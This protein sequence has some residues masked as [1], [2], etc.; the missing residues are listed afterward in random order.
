[1]ILILIMILIL[2]GAPPSGIFSPHGGPEPAA[3]RALESVDRRVQVVGGVRPIIER[4]VAL[5]AHGRHLNVHSMF[6]ECSLNVYWIF[7][8]KTSLI[9]S[10]IFTESSKKRLE[11]S[12]NVPWTF[13]EC[14]MNVP[15]MFAECSLNVPW[16]F[17]ECSLNVPMRDPGCW[18]GARIL[19]NVH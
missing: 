11:K 3:V 4:Q 12:L 10:W 7:T 2:N 13:P 6:N 9:V 17:P 16:M 15:W 14:S 5:L 18:G 1:M 8:K 19:L